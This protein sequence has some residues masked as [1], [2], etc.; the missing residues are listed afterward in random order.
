MTTAQWI[1]LAL[2]VFFIAVGA[3]ALYDIGS[4]Y[5]LPRGKP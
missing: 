3:W 4:P 5:K 1:S 2:I